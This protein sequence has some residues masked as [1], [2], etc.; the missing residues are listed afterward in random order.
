MTVARVTQ[1]PLLV[2]EQGTAVARVTQ[3]P[4]LVAEQGTSKARVT[5]AVL[6]VAE[7]VNSRRR[8]VVVEIGDVPPVDRLR[9]RVLLD[10]HLGAEVAEASGE[11][12]VWR[13]GPG[14]DHP[15]ADGE[16]L[17]NGPCLRGGD[18]QVGADLR[19]DAQA[20]RADLEEPSSRRGV[21]RVEETTGAVGLPEVRGE[22]AVG[23]ECVDKEQG[24]RNLRFLFLARGGPPATPSF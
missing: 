11:D 4:L 7:S 15:E 19:H 5:Q 10:G 6:L 9:L 14:V 8:P 23:P 22:G 20:V 1:A 24:H 18:A 21:R 17:Q 12:V 2:G 16:A 3:A 13:R